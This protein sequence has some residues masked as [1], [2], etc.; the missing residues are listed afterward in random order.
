MAKRNDIDQRLLGLIATSDI[1]VATLETD[2][3]GN[4]IID[5]ELHPDIV[6][7]LVGE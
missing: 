1:P 2:D 5:E 3:K 6:D 7:W 4:L